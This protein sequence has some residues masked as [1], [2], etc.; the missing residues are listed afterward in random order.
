M[1]K[2]SNLVFCSVIGGRASERCWVCTTLYGDYLLARNFWGWPRRNGESDDG[3]HGN[4]HNVEEWH[5]EDAREVARSRL[6]RRLHT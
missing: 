4:A 5:G 6:V 1:D 2:N 3:A